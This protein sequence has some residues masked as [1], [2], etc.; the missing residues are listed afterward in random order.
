MGKLFESV[1]VWYPRFATDSDTHVWNKLLP[2]VLL[3]FGREIWGF[4]VDFYGSISR[5]QKVTDVLLERYN[6]AIN[7]CLAFV[8]LTYWIPHD[9]LPPSIR[10]HLSISMPLP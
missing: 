10:S 2:G 7:P 5:C 6:H 4:A 8:Y 1:I 3:F 9:P